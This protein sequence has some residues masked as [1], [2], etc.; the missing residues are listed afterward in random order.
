MSFSSFL[1][2]FFTPTDISFS[3]NNFLRRLSPACVR[4][5]LGSSYYE[6]RLAGTQSCISEELMIRL[7]DQLQ[8]RAALAVR[9]HLELI[10]PFS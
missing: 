9:A 8:L 7:F 4:D 3:S 10:D 6:L 2:G 5:T 1:A